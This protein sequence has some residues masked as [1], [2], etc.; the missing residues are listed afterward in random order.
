VWVAISVLASMLSWGRNRGKH[1]VLMV[2][3]DDRYDDSG[4]LKNAR[5]T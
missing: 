1:V 5:N 4:E 3:S 2:S